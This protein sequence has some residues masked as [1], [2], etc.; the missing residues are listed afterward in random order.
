MQTVM[1]AYKLPSGKTTSSS[2]VYV[3]AWRKL[4]RPICLA[5]GGKLHSFDPSISLGKQGEP[6]ILHLP[7]WAALD[8]SKILTKKDAT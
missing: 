7:L 8:L 2:A 3:A 1:S 4:A 6:G 5:T